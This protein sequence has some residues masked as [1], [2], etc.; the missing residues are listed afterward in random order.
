MLVY[1]G[2]IYCITN[3][4]NSKQYVGQTNTTIE[5]RYA[6]HIRCA[7]S[8]DD[9]TSLLYRAMRK[10]GTD[11]FTIEKLE[12][13]SAHSREELKTILNER[14]IAFIADKNT[15]K[16]NGYNMTTGGF[17]FADHVTT[18][19]FEVDHTGLVVNHC[20]SLREAQIAT[21]IDEGNIWHS[22]RSKSHYGGSRFWYLDENDFT[23]GQN[24]GEQFR[25]KT[26]W[27]G[28]KTRPIKPVDRF[29]KD[30]QFVD[31]FDSA[32]AAARDL[33]ICQAHISKCCLGVR[34]TAGGYRWS[35]HI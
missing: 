22:C 16:P 24:I 3:S 4:I 14:E 23:V 11:K 13:V 7:K 29:T 30:G 17:A 1:T 27:H 19:V 33:H 35:F 8:L 32:S 26:N 20:P 10:Y 12:V 15:Y 2:Y 18:G 31:T 6:E 25:G 9:T 28:R 21:G 5:R 34:K